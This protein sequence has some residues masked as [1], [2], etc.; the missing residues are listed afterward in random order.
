MLADH[1]LRDHRGQP[2]CYVA[3][4]AEHVHLEVPAGEPVPQ[5]RQV[6]GFEGGDL[7]GREDEV[8][9]FS[10]TEKVVE[11]VSHCLVVPVRGLRQPQTAAE[12]GSD[13]HRVVF[14]QGLRV[15]HFQGQERIEVSLA[16]EKAGMVTA[17]LLDRCRAGL[18]EAGE[19]DKSF[20][21]HGKARP[22]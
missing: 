5:V 11:S 15:R 17:C 20:R 1:A 21:C 13:E 7:F 2:R 14:W 19:Q 9:R 10:G 16:L 18:V 22:F 3:D 8:G 6:L 12:H 4:A